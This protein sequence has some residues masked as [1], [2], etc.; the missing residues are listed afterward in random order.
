M[1][2]FQFA[3]FLSV[4]LLV[5]YLVNLYI[6]HR[7][8]QAL[9]DG[10]PMRPWFRAVFLTLAFSYPA[11]RILERIWLSPVSDVL[12]WVGSFWLGAML[13][14]FLIVLAIDLVR[15]ID[16]FIPFIPGALRPDEALRTY[17]LF[18]AVALTFTVLLAGHINAVRPQVRHLALTVNKPLVAR[19]TLRLAM[20][21]DIHMGTLVG[22]RRTA[23]MVR[24]INALEPDLI[25][26]AGDIVDEDLAPVLRFNLGESLRKL[27]AHMGVYG[28]TG[29]HEYI[30][31]AEAACRY[32]EEHGVTMLRD[33]AVLADGWLYIAGREDRDKPRFSGMPRVSLDTLLKDIDFSRPVILMDHQPFHLDKT[34]RF[35]VDLSLSGHTHHGQM[36]PLNYITR[37]IYEISRGYRKIRNTHAYVSSGYGTWGPPVRTGNRP[38]IVLIE[39]R[40]VR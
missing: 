34:A 36:W 24:D 8:L 10:S 39:L 37:A 11:A 30:G 32:L 16:F 3:I 40:F 21:S 12:T 7:G 26:L 28:I 38:E 23:R 15:A 4:V 25:L 27:K 20:V 17:L 33:S 13:Y 5:Y 1:K 6:C 2:G 19:E 9:P 22:P 35:P 14:F 29:N 31:G 18:G